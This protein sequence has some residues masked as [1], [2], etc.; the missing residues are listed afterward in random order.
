MSKTNAEHCKIYYEA[1]KEKLKKSAQEYRKKRAKLAE[2][3][4]LVKPSITEKKCKQCNSVLPIIKF[5][6]RKNRGCYESKCKSC[7]C[8]EGKKYRKDNETQISVIRSNNHK[9]RKK[10]DPLYSITHTLRSRLSKVLSKKTINTS[11]LIGVSYDTVLKWFEFNLEL[12]Y[13]T[14]MTLSNRGKFWHI[15]HVIPCNRFNLLDEKEQLICMNWTNLKPVLAHKNISK[16]DNIIIAQCLEQEIRLKLFG[17]KYNI[18]INNST[19]KNW[20]QS[21]GAL[22]TAV[23]GK[24]LAQQEV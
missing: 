15:D 9:N 10:E 12:D 1:N 14:E 11:N 6:Y 8:I 18:D 7:R 17:I 5:V 21:R 13:H 19:L 24:P 20:V 22:T 23:D 16:Q 2:E 4:K 3:N